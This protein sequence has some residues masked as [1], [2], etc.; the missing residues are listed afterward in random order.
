MC[1]VSG[2]IGYGVLPRTSSEPR[3]DLQ[4]HLNLLVKVIRHGRPESGGAS[5]E[6][7]VRL[8]RSSAIPLRGDHGAGST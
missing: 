7:D 8:L 6:V 2:S 3:A 1:S 5:S 4:P